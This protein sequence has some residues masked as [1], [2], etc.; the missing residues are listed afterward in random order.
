MTNKAERKMKRNQSLAEMIRHVSEASAE[1]RTS[2]SLLLFDENENK[3]KDVL[4][5][6]GICKA[7]M[8]FHGK[9]AELV[10]QANIII[11]EE[12]EK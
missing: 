6:M 5:I 7:V 10:D 3:T 4:F 8:E 2:H 11:E 12:N 9:L 1:A